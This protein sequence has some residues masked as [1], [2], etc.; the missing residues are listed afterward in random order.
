MPFTL[1]HPVAVLPL[2]R[3]LWFPG[4]VAGSM[5]PDLAYYTPDAVRLGGTHSLVGIVT[6]DLALG[7]VLLVSG[8]LALAPA[9]ALCP[10]AWRARVEP[11]DPL[12]PWRTARARVVAVGSMVVGG[13]THLAWDTFTHTDGVAVEHWAPLRLAVIGPHRV[14][15]V[16]GYVSSLGGMLLLMILV[17]RWYRRTPARYE[18]RWPTLVGPTRAIVVVGL[19]AAAVAGAAHALA[20]PV[21]GVSGYDWV[22]Q[23]LIGSVQGAVIGFVVYALV[24]PIVGSRSG[25]VFR[26][27]RAR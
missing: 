5:A 14:Y 12:A 23:L 27:R 7:I 3:F 25:R 24:R 8:Y 6:I 15:N 1:A 13:A 10:A 22:R 11:P 16:I 18:R 26:F 2:R 20:D 17:V 4:L 21:S 19:V 9:L